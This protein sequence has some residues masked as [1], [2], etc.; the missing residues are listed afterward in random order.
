M[1]NQNH[2]EGVML[3]CAGCGGPVCRASPGDI[4]AIS[5]RCG[6]QAPVLYDPLRQCAPFFPSSMV[7]A[8]A[9]HTRLPHMEFYLGS[10]DHESTDRTVLTGW[11][12]AA[13]A[14]SQADCPEPKC[15]EAYRTGKQEWA[16]LVD[17]RRV[18]AERA[19][20]IRQIGEP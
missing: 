8:I 14:T 2:T 16:R 7:R 4:L 6:A 19:E 12:R 20:R 5:C 10:S 17:E 13:G 1:T 11:L 18:A 15:R 9:E 3:H